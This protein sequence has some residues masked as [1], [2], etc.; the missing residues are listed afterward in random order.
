MSLEPRHRVIL[1]FAGFV[2]AWLTL[3]FM[4]DA[5]LNPR[6]PNLSIDL[7]ILF[8]LACSLLLAIGLKAEK[9]RQVHKESFVEGR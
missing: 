9:L 4:L 5:I 7:W 1:L 6:D 3:Y 2:C 8:A